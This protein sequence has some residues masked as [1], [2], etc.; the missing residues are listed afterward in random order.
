[1]SLRKTHA[2]IVFQVPHLLIAASI[3]F[4]LIAISPALASAES[5]G[6]A[7]FD[8]NATPPP[9]ATS[10]PGDVAKLS[11]DGKTARAPENA[12]K[13]V[14]DAI[15]A[16]NKIVGKPYLWGGGHQSF[17]ASGYDC[18]GAVSYALHGAGILKS[19]LASGGFMQW[20]VAGRGAWI[21]A[22][23]NPG[24]MYAIIAG[25][26]FDTSGPRPKGPNWRPVKRSSAGF[27]TRHIT[28]LWPRKRLQSAGR[29]PRSFRRRAD[30]GALSRVGTGLA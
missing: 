18:S 7:S 5:S 13:A 11:K 16:A 26:R 15:A 2:R 4:A 27:K 19:P 17:I 6:G 30:A 25:L 8:P 3:A 20:G 9:A 29:R 24:H 21:T 12:P 23:T 22:Y 1:M 28:G 10:V 14:V